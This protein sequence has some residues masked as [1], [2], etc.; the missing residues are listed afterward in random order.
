[1]NTVRYAIWC[2]QSAAEPLQFVRYQVGWEQAKA[3]A[4]ELVSV[5]NHVEVRKRHTATGTW[6][7]VYDD[8]RICPEMGYECPLEVETW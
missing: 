6:R 4:R 7:V 8:L 2:R 3:T 1:M 5:Y